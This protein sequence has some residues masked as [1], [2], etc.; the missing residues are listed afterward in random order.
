M[1]NS[2]P[3]GLLHLSRQFLEEIDSWSN[4]IYFDTWIVLTVLTLENKNVN[5]A[6]KKI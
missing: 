6:E 3:R 2:L 5:C 4:G 1:A